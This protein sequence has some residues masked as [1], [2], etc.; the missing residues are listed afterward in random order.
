MNIH[1]A[2]KL[3]SSQHLHATVFNVVD[4]GL[5]LIDLLE[6]TEESFEQSPRRGSK[7][8][9]DSGRVED[10]IRSEERVLKLEGRDI[11]V[12]EVRELSHPDR[13]AWK[14]PPVGNAAQSPENRLNIVRVIAKVSG[15][16]VHVDATLQYTRGCI[17]LSSLCRVSQLEE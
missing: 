4:L 15:G 1:L 2:L 3:H 14:L 6:K 16:E 5:Q 10:G 11:T 17:A 12:R 9:P 8:L 7:V 13:T